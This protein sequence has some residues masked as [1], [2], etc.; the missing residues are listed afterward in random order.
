MSSRRLIP[1]V[2]LKS[3]LSLVWKSSFSHEWFHSSEDGALN[4]KVAKY[5]KKVLHTQH[6]VPTYLCSIFSISDPFL[7]ANSLQ[8]GKKVGIYELL[9]RPLMDLDFCS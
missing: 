8:C 7:F 4:I 2:G 3:T 1:Q 5:W 6:S 9:V